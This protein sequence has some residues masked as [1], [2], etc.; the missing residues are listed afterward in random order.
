MLSIT[1]QSASIADERSTG[2]STTI[3]HSRTIDSKNYNILTNKLAS[4]LAN[5]NSSTIRDLS[6]DGGQLLDRS[7]THRIVA[8]KTN[9]SLS[10][11]T[12]ANPGSISKM[13]LN[14]DNP[15]VASAEL[16][17]TQGGEV[18]SGLK[19]IPVN[20]RATAKA[21]AHSPPDN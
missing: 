11:L 13:N 15:S 12:V 16:D 9:G 8:N 5:S 17:L 7:N 6:K 3:Q 20:S 10:T 1:N 18:C 14:R 4:R 19:S 21:G 2:K